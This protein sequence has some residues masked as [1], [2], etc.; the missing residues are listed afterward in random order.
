V[1]VVARRAAHDAKNETE[2]TQEREE[3]AESNESEESEEHEE[4]NESDENEESEES[5]GRSDAPIVPKFV[6]AGTCDLAL[7]RRRPQQIAKALGHA[8]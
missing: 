2:Q 1:H 8:A 4:N 6:P 3:H 7:R 5:G